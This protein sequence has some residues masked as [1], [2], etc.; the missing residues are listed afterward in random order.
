M[1]S[2]WWLPNLNA[3]MRRQTPS[4][5][6]RLSPARPGMLGYVQYVPVNKEVPLVMGSLPGRKYSAHFAQ[7]PAPAAGNVVVKCGESVHATAFAAGASSVVIGAPAGVEMVASENVTIKICCVVLDCVE[8]RSSGFTLLSDGILIEEKRLS[9]SSGDFPLPETQVPGATLESAKLHWPVPAAYDSSLTVEK[10]TVPGDTAASLT[11]SVPHDQNVADISEQLK[12]V[13]AT[14]L[15]EPAAPEV[16]TS[17]SCSS[18]VVA[19]I[20]ASRIARL[21]IKMTGD[22][23]NVTDL[24]LRL[25]FKPVAA[26][27][28]AQ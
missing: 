21:N 19:S 28:M 10:S 2:I 3:P 23:T 5:R 24:T 1:A 22:L 11:I 17:S 7:R 18:G 26:T 4:F 27:N 16:N 12:I 6:S 9:S 8:V 13:Q 20:E 14:P 25:K 15:P